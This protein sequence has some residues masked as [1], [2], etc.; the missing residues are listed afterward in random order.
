M[1]HITIHCSATPP[2]QDIGVKEIRKMH[3]DKGW[4]DIGYHDVI[5]R[6]G[7]HEIGRSISRIG[8]HVKGHN[9]ENIGICLV[10]G[11]DKNGK[12]ENNFTPEQLSTLRYLITRYV[13][14]YGIKQENIKGHRDWPGVAKAC[15]CFDVSDLLKEW[16][17]V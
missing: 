10:G 8:A 17:R 11:I 7:T 14:R 2:N 4:S 9:R 13:G 12:P 1:Q 6:D 15:P 16:E 3:T 5:R